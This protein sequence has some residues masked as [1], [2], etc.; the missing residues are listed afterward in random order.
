MQQEGRASSSEIADIT[1]TVGM[2]E[3]GFFNH[4]FQLYRL[5]AAVFDLDRNCLFNCCS[6]PILVL[7]DDDA[8]NGPACIKLDLA[9]ADSWEGWS[10][11]ESADL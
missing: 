9:I 7:A 1:N 2:Y 11:V 4:L 10:R 8:P 3:D 6:D 5:V